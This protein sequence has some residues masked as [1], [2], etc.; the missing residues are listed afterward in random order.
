M[1]VEI[2]MRADRR[3]EPGCE[4]APVAEVRRERRADFAGTELEQAVTRATSERRF[5]HARKSRCVFG[6]IAPAG[7]QQVAARGQRQRWHEDGMPLRGDSPETMKN[8]RSGF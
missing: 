4:V 8:I 6:V 1:G 5:E 3:D 7:E 2:R